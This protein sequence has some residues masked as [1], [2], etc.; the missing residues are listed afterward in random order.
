MEPVRLYLV[1]G[2]AEQARDWLEGL[3]TREVDPAAH[4]QL[5]LSVSSS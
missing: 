2:V 4:S 3:Q 5:S 1:E